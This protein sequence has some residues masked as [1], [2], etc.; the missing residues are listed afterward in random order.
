MHDLMHDSPS[1]PLISIAEAATRLGIDRSVLS[2]QAKSGAVRSYR[3]KVR[4]SEVLADRAAN[5]DLTRSGRSKGQSEP[6]Q[7]ARTPQRASPR[8]SSRA[9]VDA[10]SDARN[11]DAGETADVEADEAPNTVTVDGRTMTRAEALTLKETCLA[12]AAELQ[13]DIK[14]GKV[15]DRAEAHRDFFEQGRVHRDAWIAWPARVSILM[16]EEIRIDPA[17]GKADERVLTSVLAKYVREHLDEMGEPD[18]PDWKS[19]A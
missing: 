13:L 19:P 10:R 6:A 17:T 18:E 1:D 11:A 4:F 5:I 14:R 9:S 7:K 16:A 12:L 15:I 8:A 3:G 2:R